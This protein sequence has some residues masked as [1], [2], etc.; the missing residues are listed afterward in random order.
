MNE[1]TLRR[2]LHFALQK[3]RY[4]FIL[5]YYAIFLVECEEL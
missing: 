5:F 4:S 2:F 3:I 1:I